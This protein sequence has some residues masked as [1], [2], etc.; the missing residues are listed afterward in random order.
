MTGHTHTKQLL[1]LT[2]AALILTAAWAPPAHPASTLVFKTVTVDGKR[3]K[4][5][6]GRIYCG[7]DSVM[8]LAGRDWQ[9]ITDARE[10]ARRLNLLAEEGIRPEDIGIQRRR[11]R[12]IITARGER[13]VE[14]HGR[15]AK[16]HRS[17]PRQLARTWSKNLQS[18]FAKPYL[19]VAPV[20]VPIG[21]NRTR[22]VRG[23]IAGDLTVRSPS[24]AVSASYDSARNIINVYGRDT[25]RTELIISDAHSVLRVPVRAAQ[26][27]A[28]I[29]RPAAGGVTGNPASPLVIARAAEAA[30]GA[31][32]HLQP[33]A[34]ASVRTSAGVNSPLPAGQSLLPL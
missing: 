20:A 7:P 34:W 28:R 1:W 23:N 16:F 4:A 24:P 12:Y 8:T 29:A 13:I 9:S 30:V 25:G 22:P 3:G 10:V 26:Y 17:T 14:V 31:G 27:A 32:L 33:G 15:M 6:A 2:A 5:P 11:T 18:H 19:S 21:E